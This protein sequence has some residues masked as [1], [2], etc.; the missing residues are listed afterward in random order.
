MTYLTR[1]QLLNECWQNSRFDSLWIPA[2]AWKPRARHP[3]MPLAGVQG[4]QIPPGRMRVN[5]R[6]DYL[7]WDILGHR[8]L[9]S[10]PL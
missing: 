2:L 3:R 8:T 9:Q 10:P 6:L 1:R 4:F 7:P 5:F